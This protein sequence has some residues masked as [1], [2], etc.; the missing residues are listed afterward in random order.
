MSR[1]RR[2][3]LAMEDSSSEE[4][5]DETAPLTGRTSTADLQSFGWAEKSVPAV[6]V[7][8]LRLDLEL[9]RAVRQWTKG[10]I[11]PQIFSEVLSLS[12]DEAIWFGAGGVGSC[13]FLLRLLGVLHSSMS[14]HEE[15]CFELYGA[16]AVCIMVEQL[17]KFAFQRARPPW[18]APQKRWV[19]PAEWLSF[20]SGHSLRAFC[21]R[22]DHAIHDWHDCAIASVAIHPSINRS[23][24]SS[25]LDVC[26]DM[27]PAPDLCFLLA[28]SSLVAGVIPGAASLSTAA[29]LPW[30]L[31]VGLSRVMK[32]RHFPLDVLF[33]AVAGVV[34][35]V[36]LESHSRR[37][38]PEDAQSVRAWPISLPIYQ[39]WT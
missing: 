9:A 21:K 12:G 16:S 8:L 38:R 2:E 15:L 23:P 31:G 24:A 6:L 3:R 7:P 30:A 20:P 33:G 10:S 5:Y 37:F 18:T 17:L 14:C 29:L 34:L 25:L 22:R 4:E 32:G 19:V 26:L 39:S 36:H 11:A 13:L 27:L 35:G 28:D 1:R